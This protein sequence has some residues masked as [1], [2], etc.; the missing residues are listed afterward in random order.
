MQ[1]E[2][3]ER[4]AQIAFDL[5]EGVRESFIGAACANGAKRI[6]SVCTLIDGFQR[7][8]EQFLGGAAFVD[9]FPDGFI[10]SEI[11]GFRLLKRIGEGGFGLVYLAERNSEFYAVKV[12]RPGMDSEKIIRRFDTERQLLEQL[13]HPYIAKLI[14]VGLVNG[15]SYFAMEFIHGLPVNEFCRSRQLGL[16]ERL[17]LFAKVCEAISHAHEQGII[18]RDIK[19]GNVLVQSLEGSAIPHV[20]DFG[21]AKA[22]NSS[23]QPHVS[24]TGEA[25][26]LGS[27][28]NISPEQI[29]KRWGD[30]G[31]RSDVYALGLL[32]YEMLTN[33]A[34]YTICTTNDQLSVGP[35]ELCTNL[36]T[37]ILGRRLCPPSKRA[38][39]VARLNDIGQAMAI[40]KSLDWITLKAANKDPVH[41]YQ[42]VQAMLDDIDNCRRGMPVEARRPSFLAELSTIVRMYPIV[43]GAF[44]SAMA[45]LVVIAVAMSML[46]GHAKASERLAEERL[47]ELNHE[48]SEKNKALEQ[49]I[50]TERLL[51]DEAKTAKAIT[52]VLINDVIGPGPDSSAK[53]LH[54]THLDKLKQASH[55]VAD[56]CKS[57]PVVEATVRIA[58]GQAFYSYM[59]HPLSLQEFQRAAELRQT[60]LGPDHPDTL[61][62]NYVVAESLMNNG[63]RDQ[64][65]ILARDVAERRRR[66]L[67]EGAPATVESIHQYGRTL[68]GI[69]Q[70]EQAIDVLEGLL[71]LIESHGLHMHYMNTTKHSLAM[72][73]AA[74][75]SPTKCE[76]LLAEVLAQQ[77]E[78]LG[79]D[80]RKTL[81]TQAQLAAAYLANHKPEFAEPLLQSASHRL[82]E[83]LGL[84][85][86]ETIRVKHQ[87]GML[88]SGSGKHEEAAQ[89]YLEVISGQQAISGPGNTGDLGML[90][91]AACNLRTMGHLR[92]AEAIVKYILRVHG[93]NDDAISHHWLR[94]MAS[95]FRFEGRYVMELYWQTRTL[96]ARY[97]LLGHSDIATRD[98]RREFVVAACNCVQQIL[99][100][101]W[102]KRATIIHNEIVQLRSTPKGIPFVSPNDEGQLEL[103]FVKQSGNVIEQL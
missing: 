41:R 63:M 89:Q 46:L 66:V 87:L 60:H 38:A 20:I 16:D 82:Q 99:I 71:T 69:N 22:L 102:H 34:P 55:V 26:L 83:S 72:A 64:A 95:I 50:S 103:N 47:V 14:A 36:R 98:T 27:I 42:T 32:L 33:S 37:T 25:S 62:A 92:E 70:H 2:E 35:E 21:I 80:H 76:A 81:V 88:L 56:R 53:E 97:R 75:G 8:P 77:K 24:M 57:L 17:D 90:H 91:H 3:F 85:H 100:S 10:G 39:S 86:L 45:F 4:I 101:D 48:V 23:V 68:V 1:C 73:Y 49:V 84:N 94:T 74:D 11:D 93:V 19:P 65:A 12:I 29:S 43:C 7:T 44:G 30:V 9:P 79:L 78:I 5:P 59:Q 15:R 96:I 61:T 58:L 67:G 13:Q 54:T 31:T 40:S 28:C 51:L 6:A 18:H 52:E